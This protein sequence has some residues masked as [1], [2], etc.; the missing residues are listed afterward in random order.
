MSA[1][2]LKS[3]SEMNS[4]QLQSEFGWLELLSVKLSLLQLAESFEARGAFEN[5]WSLLELVE[6]FGALG[7]FWSL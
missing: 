5:S 7:V 3:A 1:P 2:T 4:N 6:P